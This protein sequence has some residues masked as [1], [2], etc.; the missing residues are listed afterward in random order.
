[1][2]RAVVENVLVD[3]VGDGEHVV[4]DAEVADE[5]EFLPA[6][7]LAGRVIGRVQDDGLGVVLEGLAKFDFVERPLGIRGLRRTQADEARLGAAQDRI[8]AVVFVERLEDDDL[9]ALIADRE[10]GRD[11]GFGRAAADGDFFLG[12]DVQALP[13]LHLAGDGVAQ[14]LRS[15]G[16]GVLVD[17]GGD[18]LLRGSLDLGGRGEIGES[19]G[20]VDGAVLHGLARHL[21]DDGLGEVLDLVAEIVLGLGGGLGHGE[22]D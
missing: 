8:R 1:M 11:H 13:L 22:S 4:L 9:V 15:P 16:D 14:A 20:Q 6:E 19:L 12:I 10:Q 7:H 21:A 18:G 5:L 3:F 17:V 2:L